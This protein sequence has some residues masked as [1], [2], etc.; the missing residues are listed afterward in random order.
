MCLGDRYSDVA[1]T[2][3]LP[4]LLTQDDLEMRRLGQIH[5]VLG[6]AAPELVFSAFIVDTTS[7]V[8]GVVPLS[9][10]LLLDG[11]RELH[12]LAWLR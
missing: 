12:Q 2:E 8:S 6:I 11:V 7:T 3:L 5:E 10:E 1:D 4:A 9:S